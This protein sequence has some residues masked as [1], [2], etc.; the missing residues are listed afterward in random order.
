M[1]IFL[2]SYFRTDIPTLDNEEE[3]HPIEA[4]GHFMY[5]GGTVKEEGVSAVLQSVVIS[6][7]VQT[8]MTFSYSIFVS[9]FNMNIF[10]SMQ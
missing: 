5:V 7:G 10:Y 2:Y 9:S 1:I 8:C 4:E 6:S 3:P